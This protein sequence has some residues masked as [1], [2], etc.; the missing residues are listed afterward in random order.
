MKR[1]YLGILFVFIC[2]CHNGL[3]YRVVDYDDVVDSV[4]LSNR[5]AWIV[6]GGY[7]V[8]QNAEK[9]GLSKLMS[10]YGSYFDFY[11]CDLSVAQNEHI[12]YIYRLEAFPAVILQSP[13]G[14]LY[15]SSCES[16]KSILDDIAEKSRLYIEGKRIAYK[17]DNFHISNDTLL[18]LYSFTYELYSSL[19]SYGTIS[20]SLMI[21]LLH[22]SISLNSY[23]YNNYL[24]FKLYEVIGDSVNADYY[25]KMAIKYFEENKIP[26]YK[27]LYYELLQN[28]IKESPYMVI[29]STNIDLGEVL[30]G[31]KEERIVRF[32]NIG[33]A[34]LVIL[35]ASTS[36]SC[37]NAD[38]P[39][40]VILP[41]EYGE[42]K[43]VYNAESVKGTFHKT[44]VFTTNAVN[45][46]M[47][48]AVHGTII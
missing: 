43:I 34:P 44:L 13:Q 5:A 46:S 16:D 19:N 42:I 3:N 28:D 24:G 4:R 39:A 37:V 45:N 35:N 25:K 9:S 48:L 40:D 36:C 2:G 10:K 30:A 33:Q 6:V 21:D 26:L 1:F 18:N 41:G 15:I 27:Y 47:I 20:D 8:I 31:D 22:Q 29:D 17:N 23:F 11:F 32:Q 7:N 12:N 38:W 14:V